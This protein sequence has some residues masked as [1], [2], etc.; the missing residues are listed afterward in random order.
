MLNDA[1]EAYQIGNGSSAWVRD[2]H[3][4]LPS[5]SPCPWQ[6]RTPFCELGVALK[7]RVYGSVRGFRQCG[8]AAAFPAPESA[9]LCAPGCEDAGY[10]AHAAVARGRGT[11]GVVTGGFRLAAARPF[12]GAFSYGG[13]LLGHSARVRTQLQ[14]LHR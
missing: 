11:I 10:T 14:A 6:V 1:V 7:R 8:Y 12:G 5:P 4:L 13:V 2:Q 3:D 9:F